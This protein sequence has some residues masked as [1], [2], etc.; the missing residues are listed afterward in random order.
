MREP[1]SAQNDPTS[2]GASEHGDDADSPYRRVE[3]QLRAL[4]RGLEATERS[5]SD[6]QRAMSDAAAEINVAAHQ[7]AQAFDRLGA[8]VASLTGRLERMER[9]APANGM[10]DAVKALYQ[11]LTTLADQVAHTAGQSASQISLL[12]NN[13]EEVTGKFARAQQDAQAL[14]RTLEDRLARLDERLLAL[15]K[16]DS[17]SS[18]IALEGWRTRF[19]ER[20]RTL[21]TMVEH[22]GS[23]VGRALAAMGRI[24]RIEEDLGRLQEPTALHP[25]PQ[26]P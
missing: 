24:A 14:S 16:T 7:Q 6:N 21:E 4:A 5:Q 15:E 25:D 20:V 11:G 12:A 13:I 9:R 2:G 23:E 18:H 1:R 3:D 10:K 19:D 26:P 22:Q 17:D 8:S